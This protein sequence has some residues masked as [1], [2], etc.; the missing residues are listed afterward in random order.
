VL[1]E[2]LNATLVAGTVLARQPVDTVSQAQARSSARSDLDRVDG[3]VQGLPVGTVVDARR[4]AIKLTTAKGRGR[5]RQAGRFSGAM[6]KVEQ[7]KRGK[8]RGL[9]TLRLA[10]DLSRQRCNIGHAR[11]SSAGRPLADVATHRRALLRRLR[12]RARGRFRTRG[13]Y[14]SAIV[15]GT[16]WTIEDRCEGTLVSVQEGKVAVRDLRRRRTILVRARQKYL[17]RAPGY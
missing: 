15:R 16:R 10:E 13:R 8:N 4:G 12:G 3:L 14:S 17:A 6:F 5:G 9:T 11:R 1:G 2:T 7:I